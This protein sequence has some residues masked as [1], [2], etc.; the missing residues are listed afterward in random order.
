MEHTMNSQLR[1]TP[2]FSFLLALLI[3]GFAFPVFSQSPYTEKVEIPPYDATN[4]EHF[5]IST[6]AD[7]SHIN[8]AGKRFFYVKPNA[9]YGVITITAKGTADSMRYISLYNGNDLHPAMLDPSEQAGVEFIF[10][11]AGYWVVDRMSSFHYGD[12]DH[13]CI[14]IKNRSHHIVLNRLYLSD[15]YAGIIIRGT[16]DEPYTSGIT[17]QNSRFDPMS[18]EGIDGDA[19]AI[20]LMGNYWNTPGRVLNTHILNNEMRNCNDGIMLIKMP[21]FVGNGTYWVDYPGTII[22]YNHIYTDTAVYTDGNGNHDPN[23][24]WALTENALDLKGGSDDPA[25]PVVISHNYMWGYRRTDQHGGGSGSWG[26]ALAAHYHT[27]NLVIKDNVI[28]NSNRGIAFSGLEGTPFTAE[29]VTISGNILYDIGY[30]TSGGTGYCVI[31]ND[32]KDITFEANT[33]VGVDKHSHWLEI[34]SERDSVT[35]HLNVSCN[36]IINSEKE[37]GHRSGYYTHI[38]YNSFYNTERVLACD[39][40]GHEGPSEA[41]MEDMTFST[42]RYTTHPRDITLHKVLSTSASPHI[43]TC[44]KYSPKRAAVPVPENGETMVYVHPLLSWLRVSDADS[45]DIYFGS[46]FPPP[47]VK[48]QKEISFDPGEL[49]PNTIYYWRIDSHGPAGVSQGFDWAFTTGDVTG[50]KMV[51]L[52]LLKHVTCSSEEN[53]LHGAHNLTDGII[54]RDCMRWSAGPMPQWAEVDLGK[55]YDIRRTEV[56]CYLDRG[57]RFKVEARADGSTEYTQVVDRLDNTQA[58]TIAHPITDTFPAITARYVRLTVVSGDSVTYNG[59]WASISEFRVFGEPYIVTSVKPVEKKDEPSSLLTYPNPFTRQTHI[60][61]SLPRAG[62]VTIRIFSVTGKE[63]TTLA[64]TFF[65]KGE[66]VVTWKIESSPESPSYQLYFY[67][68]CYENE[69]KTGKILHVE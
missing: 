54:G 6:K 55:N 36:V 22:D 16:R 19:V 64:N 50:L 31:F 32:A 4:A 53:H 60:R 21:Q 30:A 40:W 67:R 17:I 43:S 9:D 62:H 38:Q 20:M 68:F 24:R 23:G 33:I 45:Y 34:G 1:A 7:W 14:E 58:G 8:D 28:F 25:N 39:G 57:Y 51:N 56:V 35:E 12:A 3:M 29:D 41:Q 46:S 42:D 27:K 15:F 52:A 11:G 65:P 69:V 37:T 2:L 47:F 48:N 13:F 10:N 59:T 49:E 63:I 44:F 26:T 66:H 5:L 61:F 18:P